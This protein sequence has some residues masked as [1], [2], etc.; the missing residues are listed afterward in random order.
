MLAIPTNTN[1]ILAR[2]AVNA[3]TPLVAAN[4]SSADASSI[5]DEE[6]RTSM[7]KGMALADANEIAV[8][9]TNAQRSSLVDTVIA[10]LTQAADAKNLVQTTEQ[11]A[12][13]KAQNATRAAYNAGASDPDFQA[14]LSSRRAEDEKREEEFLNKE[15]DILNNVFSENWVVNRFHQ[16]VALKQND[17]HLENA[18]EQKQQTLQEIQ[19]LSASTDSFARIN[20][21]LAESITTES[22][23]AGSRLINAQSATDI[24]NARLAGL[25]ANAEGMV[26]SMQATSQQTAVL[27]QQRN[28]E[29]SAA[30][31]ALQKE[32]N[33]LARERMDVER[34][35]RER[36]EANAAADAEL[37][38]LQLALAK[39][40]S[41]GK[42]EAFNLSLE[43]KKRDAARDK[44]LTPLQIKTAQLRYDQAKISGPL[45]A[46]NAQAQLDVV[47]TRIAEKEA[48]DASNV[49]LVQTAQATLG[50]TPDSP[51]QIIQGVKSNGELGAKYQQLLLMGGNPTGQVAA[52]PYESKQVLA[53]IDPNGT[54][55]ESTGT[56][57]LDE[58]A[59]EQAANYILT[60]TK[61]AR[62][63]PTAKAD[64]NR[65]ADRVMLKYASNIVKGDT[66]NPM[67][68]PPMEA[69][70]GAL[71]VKNTPFYT[72]VIAGTD[73]AEF[74]P[75]FLIDK[76]VAAI[77]AKTLSTEEVAQGILAM[78]ITATEYNNTTQGGFHR[79]GLDNQT[80]YISN[81]KRPT[82][83]F[84]GIPSLLP[85]ALTLTVA[86][87][88]G[89]TSLGIDK[90]APA[91]IKG[92]TRNMKVDL[93][94]ID[95]IKEILLL[96]MNATQAATQAATGDTN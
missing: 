67:H 73:K 76:G 54:A 77:N 79:V 44:T 70:T 21:Q 36:D 75:Q 33:V 94:N 82:S 50:L 26:A 14:N 3:S 1:P 40:T 68:A 9:A 39:D 62:D 5:L 66:S 78:T 30:Q 52:D 61:P 91:L 27:M 51:A 8:Q 65:A 57:L 89:G 92:A 6:I 20:A 16:A 93:R 28:L 2:A 80:T 81:L 31:I 86:S 87:L 45:A 64:F 41:A 24:A 13:L 35:N 47:T 59:E 42:V 22:I 53:I 46:A 4:P 15:Q 84:E 19:G 12:A 96:N 7:R 17:R 43:Q 18:R 83:F 60:G 49:Y 63:E 69:I 72:K 88:G 37:K 55:P 11:V 29:N 95:K 34:G 71:R 74:D 56:K 90:V 23:A 48:T 25:N 85:S 58:I 32:K 10:G 38:Q